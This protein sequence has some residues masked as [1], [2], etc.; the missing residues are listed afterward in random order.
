MDL[1]AAEV[2]YFVTQVAN[3][4]ASFGVAKED[5]TVVGNAINGLFGMRCSAPATVVPAQGAQ[6]QAI[7]IDDTCPLAPNATCGAYGNAVEPSVAVESLVPSMTASGT[8]GGPSATG[9]AP[10]PGQPTT[11]GAEVR[12]W[13]VGAVGVAAGV[14]VLLL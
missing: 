8:P 7:C 5:L 13:S 2:G 12:G 9:T 3:S 14:V 11:G 6:L 4:A 1:S 10:A